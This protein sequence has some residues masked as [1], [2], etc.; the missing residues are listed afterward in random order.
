MKKLIFAAL[1]GMP[2]FTG[3]N[4]S[5]KAK[6]SLLEELLKSDWVTDKDGYSLRDQVAK[7]A[8]VGVGRAYEKNRDGENKVRHIAG[9]WLSGD[10]A[11]CAYDLD[12]GFYTHNPEQSRA[13]GDRLKVCKALEAL[14]NAHRHNI[15]DLLGVVPQD[16]TAIVEQRIVDEKPTSEITYSSSPFPF[17]NENAARFYGKKLLPQATIQELLKNLSEKS[18]TEQRQEHLDTFAK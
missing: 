10:Q 14:F 2:L 18:T 13:E 6:E 16:H 11:Y 4:A 8:G 7:V 9:F 5:E 3:V 12:N 1:M 15:K 17:C